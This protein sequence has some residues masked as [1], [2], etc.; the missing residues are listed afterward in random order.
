MRRCASVQQGGRQQTC[1]GQTCRL[2][3]SSSSACPMCIKLSMMRRTTL[4]ADVC[5]SRA[6][7]R[8]HAIQPRDR[9]PQGM[10]YSPIIT[11]LNSRRDN[12]K[13]MHPI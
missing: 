10:L 11:F 7:P 1:A 13:T 5:A 4:R 6:V 8:L 9:I 3:F 12:R 2:E